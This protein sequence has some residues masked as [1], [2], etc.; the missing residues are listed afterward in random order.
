[1]FVLDGVPSI[2]NLV[3]MATPIKQI[4]FINLPG[5]ASLPH[6]FILNTISDDVH[7]TSPD[8]INIYEGDSLAEAK[9]LLENTHFDI[10]VTNVPSVEIFSTVRSKLPHATTILITDTSMEKYSVSL[11]GK[12]DIFLD[13]VI[14]NRYPQKWTINELRV[15]LKKM[16]S[17]DLFGI[18]KYME[19]GSFINSQ[20]ITRSAD[21]DVYNKLVMKTAEDAGLSQHLSKL[22]FGITEEL[23][24]NA[25]YDAPVASGNTYYHEL[26]RTTSIELKPH[27]YS[28]LSYAFDCNTFAIAVQDPFGALKRDKFFQYLKKVISR[29][30]ATHLIDSKKGGA[31]LGLFKI[32]YSSHSL[33]CNIEAQKRTEVIALIDAHHQIRDFSK[34]PRSVH[35]FI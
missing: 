20:I 28:T 26:P 6:K 24:M 16:T 31:G 5:H 10:V 25:I 22:I 1:M 2:M 11:D 32:L 14:A 15:T 35:Y 8:H 21:R 23:L 9:S 19:P 4:C 33:V 3:K 18:G 27:E 17:H 7:E 12:E 13:H 30:D 29:A 34:M